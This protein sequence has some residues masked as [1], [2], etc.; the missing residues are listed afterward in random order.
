MHAQF[1]QY[2][3]KLPHQ[4]ID[5][6][7]Q[8]PI[9]GAIIHPVDWKDDWGR[10]N[11]QIFATLIINFVQWVAKQ[12]LLRRYFLTT[13]DHIFNR[14]QVVDKQHPMPGRQLR[15]EL[16]YGLLKIAFPGGLRNTDNAIKLFHRCRAWGLNTVLNRG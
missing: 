10:P 6:P 1:F 7:L 13:R 4:S 9:V 8:D 16:D 15:H 2:C 12:Q 14:I 3:S 11:V 5:I